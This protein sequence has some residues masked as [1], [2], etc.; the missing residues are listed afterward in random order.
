MRQSQSPMT[1]LH[2]LNRRGDVDGLRERMG[3]LD[4]AALQTTCERAMSLFP[5]S[6]YAG[7]DLLLMPGLRR[8]AVLEM[9]AFGD[10]LPNVLHRGLDPYAAELAALSLEGS[11]PLQP[12]NVVRR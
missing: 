2:L 12:W 4:W 10:L 11:Q 7:I 5:K 3:M 9:N 1:N 6:L 8:H